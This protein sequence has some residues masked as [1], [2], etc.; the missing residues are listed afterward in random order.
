M[1]SA[2][3]RIKDG[4]GAWTEALAAKFRGDAR[5]P[6]EVPATGRP[7]PQT[8]GDRSLYQAMGW[9]QNAW[10]EGDSSPKV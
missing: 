10:A 4:L 8:E 9:T 6:A 7:E 1:F 2:S 5:R 3:L